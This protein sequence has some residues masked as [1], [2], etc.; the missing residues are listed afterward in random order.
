VSKLNL[1]YD[2]EYEKH[3]NCNSNV[4]DIMFAYTQDVTVLQ[5]RIAELEKAIRD[6]LLIDEIEDCIA[7]Y[8]IKIDD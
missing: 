3:E 1:F 7:A 8:L 5:A 6:F 4:D 2:S